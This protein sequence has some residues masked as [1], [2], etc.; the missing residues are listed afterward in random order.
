MSIR[1]S[2][3]LAFCKS[4]MFSVIDIISCLIED[5]WTIFDVDNTIDFLPVNDND[6]Y[7]WQ[8]E[9]MTKQAI[10]DIIKLKQA[11]K[12]TIGINLYHKKC[13]VGITVLFFP[14]N[15]MSVMCDINRKKIC[16][17]DS[18]FF[19]DFNWYIES[20]IMILKKKNYKIE[21]FECKEY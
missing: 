20:I 12:E 3:D 18:L 5:D 1:S 10:F 15:E 8:K 4:D 19:T 6:N 16:Y 11:R 21:Y 17:S 2:I 7:D 9:L 13:S 14:N